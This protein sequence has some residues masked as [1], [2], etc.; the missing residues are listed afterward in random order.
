[1][2]DYLLKVA[3]LL[4]VTNEAKYLPVFCTSLKEQNYS[5][6]FL[7]VLDNNCKDNS[8]DIIRSYFPE[9][10]MLHVN[11][12]IGFAKGNNL[13]VEKA[14]ADGSELLF[15]LNLYIELEK[16]CISAL[17]RLINKGKKIE[18]FAPIMFFGN[19]DKK[20]NKI[21]SYANRIDCK[22]ES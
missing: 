15:I 17:V 5:D 13:Y 11:E 22:K 9:S 14:I 4:V 16:N 12:N 18:A 19:Y 7:F 6:I 10:N 3:A 20:L 21:Q 1:M 2:G 8:I